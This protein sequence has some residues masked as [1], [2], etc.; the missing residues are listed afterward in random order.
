M[1]QQYCSC[2]WSFIFTWSICVTCPQCKQQ[3]QLDSET[4]KPTLQTHKTPVCINRG[5][6]AG[7]ME[8]NC[9]V[10][11]NCNLLNKLC[12]SSKPIDE[13]VHAKVDNQSIQLT[14]KTFQHC[15]TCDYKET[16]NE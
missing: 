8:C 4:A 5:D 16:S 14:K 9:G 2:G 3:V 6:L 10:V 12:S 15:G 13:W 11:Y 7:P 1:K